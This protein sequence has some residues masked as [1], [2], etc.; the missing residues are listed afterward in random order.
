MRLKDINLQRKLLSGFLFVALMVIVSAIAGYL[1]LNRLAGEMNSVFEEKLPVK[2]VSMEASISL[3]ELQ[4]SAS[5]Y[6]L[7]TQNLKKL[8][9][10]IDSQFNIVQMWLQVLQSGTESKNF[11]KSP[12]AGIYKEHGLGITVPYVSTRVKKLTSETKSKLQELEK[13][14]YDS[15]RARNKEL[16]LYQELDKTEKK[17]DKSYNN[18]RSAL[19]KIDSQTKDFSDSALLKTQLLLSRLKSLMD[20]YA[21]QSTYDE[22]RQNKLQKSYKQILAS[23]DKQNNQLPNAIKSSFSQFAQ[24]SNKLMRTTDSA[25]QK[26]QTALEC[27]KMLQGVGAQINEQL[28]RIETQADQ[29]M[30]DGISASGKAR[31]NG[32]MTLIIVAIICVGLAIILG[33]F[34]A[35]RVTASLRKATGFADKIA[36]GD[37]SVTIEE[38][39][40][41]EIGQLFKALNQ[42]V[43]QLRSNFKDIING[44]S[45]ISS[46]SS[47]LTEVSELMASNA[48][49]TSQK[50][51]TVATAAEEMSSNMNSIAA[52]VVQAS[53]NI[54]SVSSAA[55]EMNTSIEEIVGNTEKAT[56]I[57]NQAYSRTQEASEQVKQLNEAAEAIGK[58]TETIN[59]ISAQTNLLALNATIEAARAGEAGKGFAVVANE[60]KELAQQTNDATEEIKKKIQGIQESTS[61]TVEEITQISNVVNEVTEIVSSIA[62]SM[63]QQ[64]TATKDIAENIAQ[65]SQGVSEVTENVSQS[66]TV[67]NDVAKDIVEVHKAGQDT[68]KS[69]TQVNTSAQELKKLSTQLQDILKNYQTGDIKFDIGAVKSAHLAWR[70]R[71]ENAISGQESINPEDVASDRECEFGKWFFSAEG[72]ALSSYPGFEEVQES[73]HQVHELA[74]EIVTLVNGGEQNKAKQKLNRF[75]KVREDLFQA[76][77]KLYRS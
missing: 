35:R 29:E 43:T 70:S 16:T 38:E 48:E 1:S 68:A 27:K 25:L 37:F 11:Q 42:S 7:S 58:V 51:N 26:K 72:Q 41:D 4:S 75:E 13:H 21:A 2:D 77:D 33:I 40:Q 32:V 60:I 10:E 36:Q 45:T 17:L 76:L 49:L 8:K 67:A 44:V 63:E 74:R 15:I 19:A 54:A 73:H 50:S 69:S 46:S 6:L 30:Q 12:A 22:A 61:T 59:A 64:S 47:G 23:W 65:A 18:L 57:T 56:E 34:I 5:D 66:S 52:A 9:S 55:E 14:L 53:T 28:S 3:L 71:L 39:R 20:E 31:S 24:T 62:T